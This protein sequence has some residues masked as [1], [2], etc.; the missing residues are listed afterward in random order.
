MHAHS[1]LDHNR[2]TP[3]SFMGVLWRCSHPH[4]IE[5]KHSAFD[6]ECA[7]TGTLVHIRSHEMKQQPFEAFRGMRKATRKAIRDR[8]SIQSCCMYLAYNPV[9]KQERDPNCDK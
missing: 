6:R 4:T 3:E 2:S 9:D 8:S 7:E 1:T 5:Y